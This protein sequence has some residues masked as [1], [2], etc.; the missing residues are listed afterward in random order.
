MGGYYKARAGLAT[1]VAAL[2]IAGC[3]DKKSSI[4]E[5]EPQETAITSS[6]ERAEGFK[7][8]TG[9]VV[10]KGP[11]GTLYALGSQ[12]LGSG[13]SF[14]YHFTIPEGT[15][16]IE[17][18]TPSGNTKSVTLLGRALPKLD[19]DAPK[20]VVEDTLGGARVDI[21]PIVPPEAYQVTMKLDGKA[22]AAT[23]QKAYVT[24]D[25]DPK[26][27]SS[28]FFTLD[29][30]VRG[31][32]GQARPLSSVSETVVVHAAQPQE[33]DISGNYALNTYGFQV[34]SALKTN[35]GSPGETKLQLKNGAKVY[36][37]QNRVATTIEQPMTHVDSV[38]HFDAIATHT[39]TGRA[40]TTA[41]QVNNYFLRAAQAFQSDSSGVVDASMPSLPP[42]I[43]DVIAEQGIEAKVVFF[44]AA[45][46][47]LATATLSSVSPISRV[48]LGMKATTYTTR[49]GFAHGA[50]YNGKTYAESAK[51]P[52]GR[53]P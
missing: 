36:E 2:A 14:S 3:R 44:G 12:P 15:Q 9:T 53:R 21:V 50:P 31:Y 19:I 39:A 6:I 41:V 5:P 46:D 4:T 33:V 47:S 38:A 48:R 1:L 27:T 35:T 13:A 8:D 25:R 30:F 7:G 49:Y 51:L 11:E 26:R 40:D 17:A 52:V 43:R 29:G 45:G 20:E 23:N 28:H 22:I 34:R 37:A 10:F 32:N 24:S 18:K 16:T 42:F